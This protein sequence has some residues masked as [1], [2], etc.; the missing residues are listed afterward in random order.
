[1]SSAAG[2]RLIW[3]P[4]IHTAADL[5][6]L[7]G[8]VRK[9]HQER[10]GMAQW[11]DRVKQVNQL[12][13]SIRTSLFQLELDWSGV[14]LYQDGLPVCGKEA[15]IVEDLAREGSPNHRLLLELMARGAQ[16]L[17]T[18]SPEL[19]V[20]EYELNRQFLLNQSTHVRR[21]ESEIQS[22]SRN[23]LDQRV[24]FIARRIDEPLPLGQVGCL[25]LGLM[26]SLEGRLPEDM[27]VTRLS[28][29]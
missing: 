28:G 23:L 12:W 25:F 24:A 1:M 22:I 20:Q 4:I 16:L 2:R 26:Y 10:A 7:Q 5:G 6:S 27:A 19:L 21:P 29:A 11:Q 8:A 9:L 18:E 14:F 13:R 3:V 17:G 15:Q